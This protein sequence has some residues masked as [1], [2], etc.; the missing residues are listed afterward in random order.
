MDE[1]LDCE[2]RQTRYIVDSPSGEL[3]LKVDE[4]NVDVD[5][6]LIGYGVNDCAFITAWNPGLERLPRLVNE[7]RQREL[8]AEAQKRGYKVLPG[9]G[10]GTDPSWIPEE[11]VF[12]IGISGQDAEEL[13]ADFGQFAIIVK[14]IS[15]AVQIRYT[16]TARE[17]SEKD[18]LGSRIS[19]ITPPSR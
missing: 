15:E 17:P 14:H 6:I 9:R 16:K 19:N 18:L 7:Q 11:S 1:S 5:A 4:L 2:Y 3:V 12:I 10:V 13:G 8:T